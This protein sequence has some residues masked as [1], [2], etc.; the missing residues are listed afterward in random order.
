MHDLVKSVKF[1]HHKNNNLQNT[2][3]QHIQEMK[4]ETRLY[5][6]AD[7]THNFYKV[8]PEMHK[9][10]LEKEIT[11]EYKKAKDNDL[12]KLNKE[13]KTIAEELEIQDRLYAF[14]KREAFISIKDHKDN[15]QN[16]T[17]CRL[18]NPAKSDLGK[19]SKKILT[20]IV[21]SVKQKN[22]PKSLEK[23]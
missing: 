1:K 3:K 13:D 9:E 18:I 14:Q 7:K 22:V 6:A 16:N 2:M 10:M 5:V 4:N 8:T 21:T 15:F 20:R 17:K 12:N 23:Y 19:V 11:K